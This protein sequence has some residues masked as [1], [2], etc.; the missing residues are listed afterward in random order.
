MINSLTA[1]FRHLL[2]FSSTLSNSSH[3]IPINSKVYTGESL[4][5]G[6][7]GIKKGMMSYWDSWG[8][9]HAVTILHVK[10]GM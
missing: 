6:A 4:R 10:K 1:N 9:R 8:K 5:T 7:L 2:R 3:P